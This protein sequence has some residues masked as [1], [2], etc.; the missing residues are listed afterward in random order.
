MLFMSD[1]QYYILVKLCRTVGSIHSFKTV[2]RLTP[3]HMKLKR[4]IIL[5]ILEIDWKEVSVT[6]NG[7]KVNL[8]NSVII[9]FR[10]K[11]KI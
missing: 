9:P 10:D 5:D 2:G 3:K 7:N 1:V 6:L 8:P 11:F 4:N